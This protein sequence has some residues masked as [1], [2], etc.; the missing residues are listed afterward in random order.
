MVELLGHINTI[1]QD[2]NAILLAS[3]LGRIYTVMLIRSIVLNVCAILQDNHH[4]VSVKN[5]ITSTSTSN[6]IVRPTLVVILALLEP[7]MIL[8]EPICNYLL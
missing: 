8:N 1:G 2:A 5:I 6:A 7:L 3:I 4:Y